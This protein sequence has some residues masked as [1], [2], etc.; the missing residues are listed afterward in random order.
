MDFIAK[1]IEFVR[2]NGIQAD[3][4]V[5]QDDG[6]QVPDNDRST[7]VVW[8]NPD[9]S[10]LMQCVD[11][12]EAYADKAGNV[13]IDAALKAVQ[14]HFGQKLEFVVL[15]DAFMNPPPPPAVPVGPVG[16]Q[17]PAALVAS[18]AQYGMV[19]VDRNYFKVEAG[20]VS[21]G[22]LVTDKGKK[23]R[24]VRPNFMTTWWMEL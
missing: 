4:R 24:A 1:Y 19:A 20:N 15:W 23:Y 16:A 6:T 13:N 14:L 11:V 10:K 8:T 12:M 9:G 3:Y 18:M 2:A 7:Y 21:E 17:I 5:A 22:Q